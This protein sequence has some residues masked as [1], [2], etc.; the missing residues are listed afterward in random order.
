MVKICNVNLVHLIFQQVLEF[1]FVSD[2]CVVYFKIILLQ[3]K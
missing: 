3:E 1:T 2:G